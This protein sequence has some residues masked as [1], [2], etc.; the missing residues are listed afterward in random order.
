[1]TGDTRESLRERTRR[2]VHQEI[3]R[4]AMALFAERG[5]EDTTIEQ[6]AEHAGISRRSFF[7]YFATKEDVV[8]GELVERGRIV[9]S[10]LAERPVDEPPWEAIR[11]ALLELRDAIAATK[12]DDLEIGRMLYGT[13]TLRARHLEKQLAWQEL[14]VP[15]LTERMR[16]T[17]PHG[18]VD[19]ELAAA[20]VVVGALACLDVA[21]ARWVRDDGA[22]PLERLYDDAVAAI[23]S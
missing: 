5:F 13:P 3:A 11:A 1:M 10:A 22:T 12:V 4:T 20:A 7:R 16:A 8:L 18:G 9:A 14:L 23:R 21:S 15:I 19:P 6:I 17:G 2:A